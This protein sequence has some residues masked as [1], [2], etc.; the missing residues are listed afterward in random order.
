MSDTNLSLTRYLLGELSETEQA[1]LEERYF[2]DPRVFDEV[3]RAESELVD[4]YV[5]GQLASATRQRF[6]QI[7]LAD[8][9]RRERVRFA[10]MLAAKLDREAAIA[11]ESARRL[12]LGPARRPRAVGGAVAALLL[13]AVVSGAIWMAI[14]SRRSRHAPTTAAGPRPGSEGAGSVRPADPPAP[15]PAPKS[16]ESHPAPVIA[17][18]TLA[19]GSGDR[20]PGGGPATTLVLAP[21]TTDV[22]VQLEL[23]EHDYSTYRAVLHRIGGAEI[24]RRR[25]L[26][27]TVGT[28]GRVLDF[29]LPASRFE[30][31]DY[32]LTLQGIT[33]G[34]ETDDLSQILFRVRKP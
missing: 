26:V 3:A 14:E 9:R 17:T 8:P 18:L 6:E 21:A 10:E 22:Q 13:V 5:R 12:W 25:N 24:F 1:A 32:L 29:G 31:G 33:S 11:P 4:A 19:I 7:Y 28:S 2:H 27:P 15:P 34:G 30:A 20:S 23:E 16:E